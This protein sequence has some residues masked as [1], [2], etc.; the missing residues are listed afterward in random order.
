MFSTI[1]Q[2]ITPPIIEEVVPESAAAKAGLL[3]G[4]HVM[5]IDG[6]TID[7]FDDL[8]RIVR[9]SADKP[10]KIVVDRGGK[11]VEILATPGKTTITDRFGNVMQMGQLGVKSTNDPAKSPV[12]TY[13][14]AEALGQALKEC[15]FIVDRTLVFL[16]D[17]ITGRQSSD[18]LGGPIKIAQIS[19]QIASVGIVPLINLIALLSINIGLINLFPI[20]ILDGG[21]LAFYGIEAL[22]GQ[23]LS[24]RIQE[25]GFRIGLALVVMLMVFVSWNDIVDSLR[26]FSLGH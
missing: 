4:D 14:P 12:R 13:N 18:Q 11:Q 23:P 22:R 25:I 10:I 17:V 20:P 7:T 19:G 1:G 9:T 21:H 3:A 6:F 2:R 15:Y 5:V 26:R 24:D 8:S 16:W